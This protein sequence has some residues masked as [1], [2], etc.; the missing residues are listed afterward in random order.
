MLAQGDT[1]IE[2]RFHG[3]SRIVNPHFTL[4]GHIALSLRNKTQFVTP[5]VPNEGRI[6]QVEFVESFSVVGR[7]TDEL[8]V[9]HRKI[10]I[11][12]VHIQIHVPEEL[13]QL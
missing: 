8:F 5:L 9:E 13:I 3:I 12:D 6:F 4:K 11:V 1:S 10:I 7:W 2:T